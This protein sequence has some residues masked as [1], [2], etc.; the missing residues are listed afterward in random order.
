MLYPLIRKKEI[1]G[2]ILIAADSEKTEHSLENVEAIRYL[3]LQLS[4]ALDNVRILQN[5]QEHE[6]IAAIGAFASGLIHNLKNP[7]DGLRMIIEML[8]HEVRDKDPQKAYVDELY[9]GIMQLKK[10]LIKSFDFVNYSDQMSDEIVINDLV[11]NIVDNYHKSGYSPFELLLG[12]DTFIVLCDRD[13][14]TFA[15]ENIIQNAVEASDMVKPIRIQSQISPDKR[16]GIVDIVDN[17]AGIPDDQLDKIFN[18]FYS[19]RGKGRGL[20]LTLTRNIISNHGGVINVS[21]KANEGTTFSVI[22]PLNNGT[23]S[24]A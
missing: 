6:K 5:L 19:T 22:L 8:K 24:N 17:G 16:K 2:I 3:F 23:N 15:F 1:L 7:I 20:G 4:I 10:R 9:T 12:T 13:Q 21:S 14:L 11:T 18:M